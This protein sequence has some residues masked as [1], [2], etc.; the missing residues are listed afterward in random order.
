MNF[1]F[2]K[3]QQCEWNTLFQIETK[4]KELIVILIFEIII[5]GIKYENVTLECSNPRNEWAAYWNENI[6]DW[7]DYSDFD[8]LIGNR[9]TTFNAKP[10]GGNLSLSFGGNHVLGFARWGFFSDKV[11]FK[12]G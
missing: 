4:S 3:L 10:V 6:R 11:E 5:D 1:D 8:L 12:C 7:I 9:I 2:K